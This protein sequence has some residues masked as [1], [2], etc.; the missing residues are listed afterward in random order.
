[1]YRNG[2][3]CEHEPQLRVSQKQV[4]LRVRLRVSTL[5]RYKRRIPYDQTNVDKGKAR[6]Y[7]WRAQFFACWFSWLARFRVFGVI[8]PSRMDALQSILKAHQ[9]D[10]ESGCGRVGTL[11]TSREPCARRLDQARRTFAQAIQRSRRHSNR[12]FFPF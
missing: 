6:T 4:G 3:S 1:M 7:I 12:R 10:A 2:H 9:R 5:D 11:H 8:C